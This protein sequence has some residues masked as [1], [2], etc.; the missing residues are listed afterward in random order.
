MFFRAALAQP[1]TFFYF[2]SAQLLF[3]SAN[4][5]LLHVNGLVSIN[6]QSI[7]TSLNTLFS[8]SASQPHEPGPGRLLWLQRSTRQTFWFSFALNP[9]FLHEN[10]SDMRV[11]F[12]L[13]VGIVLLGQHSPWIASY[14]MF[15]TSEINRDSEVVLCI[16][17]TDVHSQ[18]SAAERC[19][20]RW[21]I[22]HH[23]LILLIY[24]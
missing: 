24:L 2:P 4:S 10:L 6:L 5:P 12:I 17:N 22:S 13:A 21:E 9:L 7:K 11:F 23:Y 20:D 18:S 19:T 8:L 15:A 16:Q 3:Q 14:Y 1:G